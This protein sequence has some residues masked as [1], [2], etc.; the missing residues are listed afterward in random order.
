M[1]TQA[2]S[3][4]AQGGARRF[5]FSLPSSPPGRS[6]PAYMKVHGEVVYCLDSTLLR[7]HAFARQFFSRFRYTRQTQPCPITNDENAVRP[8]DLGEHGG[9]QSA[10]QVLEECLV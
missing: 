5:V 7:L 4:L 9:T 6:H 1:L 3:S 10:K 8:P 2:K